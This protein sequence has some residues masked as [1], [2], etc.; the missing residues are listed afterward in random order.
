MNEK[1]R[2]RLD[3]FP[4]MAIITALL[5]AL[6]TFWFVANGSGVEMNA[7]LAPLIQ[8]SVVWIFI[9]I[10]ARPLIIPLLPDLS[11][12]VIAVFFFTVSL[13]FGASNLSCIL[14]GDYF[15]TRLFRFY[16]VLAFSAAMAFA[17]YLYQ[18]IKLIGSGNWA[19]NTIL[20]LV[21]VA[22]F[23]AI[24]YVFFAIGRLV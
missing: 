3:F 11:R 13:I 5:D 6:T 2:Y 20:L 12:I 9:Y 1:L 21:F 4:V 17:A 10:F 7:V 15:A 16:G 23:I 14:L 22:S 8:H 19:F 18:C 24:E